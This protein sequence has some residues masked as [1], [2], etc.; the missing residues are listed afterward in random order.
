MVALNCQ[1]ARLSTCVAGVRP[2]FWLPVWLVVFR[3]SWCG[4]CFCVFNSFHGGLSVAVTPTTKRRVPK[5][6][7]IVRISSNLKFSYNRRESIQLETLAGPWSPPTCVPQLRGRRNRNQITREQPCS[8]EQAGGHSWKRVYLCHL[9]G[10]I[11]VHC[12]HDNSGLPTKSPL[13]ILDP[14][15]DTT[16]RPT[17]NLPLF[18]NTPQCENHQANTCFLTTLQKRRLFPQVFWKEIKFVVRAC[19]DFCHQVR[20]SQAEEN[21]CTRGK[22]K[23]LLR[24]FWNPSKPQCLVPRSKMARFWSGCRP[25]CRQAGFCSWRSDPDRER[26]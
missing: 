5:L 24:S 7:L 10:K 13:V 20:P 6:Q 22:K 9:S 14:H 19:F 15:D 16:Q 8:E 1:T 17:S 21:L 3:S 11:L 26:N 23:R 4:L 2:W 25:P 18:A 12:T